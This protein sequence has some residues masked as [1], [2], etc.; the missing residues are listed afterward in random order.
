[1]TETP[2]ILKELKELEELER[3]GNEEI[4]PT[5]TDSRELSESL[6]EG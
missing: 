6:S 1:M 4:N 5:V 2:E 3:A